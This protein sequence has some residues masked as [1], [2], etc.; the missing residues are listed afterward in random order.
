VTSRPY[1]K[2][3]KWSLRVFR[4]Y[5]DPHY[6]DDIEGDL[7]ERFAQRKQQHKSANWLLVL[8]VIRLFRPGIIR[9]VGKSQK[10]NHYGM[11]KNYLIT[12]V[13]FINRERSFALM[14]ITGLALGIACALIAYKIVSHE[15][16]YNKHFSNY[17]HIYRLI[18]EDQTPQG[19]IY[20]RQQIHPLAH[21][22]R[23]EYPSIQASM[24]YYQVDALLSVENLNGTN[25]KYNEKR[26]I[27]FVE[28]SFFD[29]FSFD[30]LSGNPASA[31]DQPGKVVITKAK[32]EKYFDLKKGEYHR[33]IG[34]P[35]RIENSK[36]AYV[37]AVIDNQAKSNDFPFEVIF[38]YEDQ[39]ASNPWYRGGKR[40]DDYNSNVNCYLMLTPSADPND[41][42]LSLQSFKDKYL[43]DYAAS[44]RTYR[45]Q[46]L[47]DLHHSDQVRMT[48]AG[49]TS[50]KSELMIMG[51][52]GLFLVITACINFVNL[53]TA[54]AVKRSK[55]VGVRKTM[56]G[57]KGHLMFQFLTETF[58]ITLLA[59][60]LGLVIAW[61]IGSQVE[62]IF[63][64]KVSIDLFSDFRIFGFLAALILLVT[65]VAGSYPAFILSNLNPILAIKN[66]LNARQ[67]SGFLSLRRALVVFQFAITQLLIISILVL[68]QQL[69]FWKNKDLGFQ[70]ESII[71][72]KLPKKD[73]TNLQVLKNELSDF[74]G[75]AG[76]SFATSGPMSDWQ[77]NNQ[78]FHPNI[79]GEEHWG[80]LKNV[81]EDYFGLYELTLIAG[82]TI[83]DQDLQDYV[84][85]N[86]KLS[87]S[88][89]FAFPEES[90]GE[91]IQYGRGDMHLKIVGVVEDFHAGS[92][93]ENMDNVIMSGYDWNILQVGIKLKSTDHFEN[94]KSSINHIEKIWLSHFP[95]QVFDFAFYHDQLNSYYQLEESVGKISRIFAVMAVI[96]GALGLYGLV[97][98]IANQKT[99]EIGIRKVLGASKWNILRI[100][101]Y[102]LMLLMGLAFL[103][104]GPTAYWIMNE[105]LDYYAYRIT[106]GPLVF[107][108]ALLTS[109]I[110]TAVTVGWKSLSVALANPI[111]SLRDE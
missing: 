70:D 43:P 60:M 18:N 54:Q 51:I 37:S 84:V 103:I 110:V 80:N 63:K 92:L 72:L 93:R 89:G 58:V 88:L 20:T 29:I 14:N 11:L 47:A 55:E 50:T 95:N 27:A 87:Q 94:V 59:S 36:T 41:F 82:R 62:Q 111:L 40:W 7:I 34:R 107:I 30:F 105:Y 17:N 73:T 75:I 19:T 86:R 101:S 26:G 28:P 9:S 35:I 38:H 66:S 77:T 12:S 22:L 46:S 25:N 31:L 67:T 65:V 99:K 97:A 100:F 2:I 24:T 104:A 57:A 42:E 1:N 56:G 102:E 85:I 98:F 69:D 32:A 71:T 76:V 44:K 45:L 68:N 23:E 48:Y 78:L 33:A 13:R 21:A 90:L 8:D 74:T 4:W 81:D 6:A 96:I 49:I 52:I 3:A 61:A 79:E 53:S 15:L 5:C 39:G 16:S 64:S 83:S 109:L 91:S 10:L 108:L 106:I